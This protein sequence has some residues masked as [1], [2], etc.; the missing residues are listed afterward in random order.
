MTTRPEDG[1]RN[2]TSEKVAE[3][4]DQGLTVLEIARLLN[5]SPAAIYRQIK[6]HGLTLPRE[7]VSS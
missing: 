2:G 5:I 6:R 4:L 7:R 1:R 3:Y